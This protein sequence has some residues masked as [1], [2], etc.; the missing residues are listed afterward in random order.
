MSYAGYKAVVTV[1]SSS[2]SDAATYVDGHALVADGDCTA[3]I[4][5]GTI[6]RA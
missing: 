6:A 1:C 2:I 3:A 5:T 4:A